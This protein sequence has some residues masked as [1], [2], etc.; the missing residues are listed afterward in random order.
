MDS[1]ETPIR[2]TGR[3]AR[4]VRDAPERPRLI[5]EQ[6]TEENDAQSA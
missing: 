1:E 5:I 4:G 2:G 6:P 3:G